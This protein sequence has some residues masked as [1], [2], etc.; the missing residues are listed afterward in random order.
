[1]K[2]KD[3][4]FKRAIS[5]QKMTLITNNASVT[6]CQNIINNRM[7][8]LFSRDI[9]GEDFLNIRL[10]IGDVKLKC[11]IDYIKPDYTPEKDK[12]LD[13]IDHLIEENKYISD[14]PFVISL[15][16]NNII[17]FILQHRNL[18]DDYMMGILLQLITYHSYF[19]LKL[20]VLTSNNL[21]E[22]S[23]LKYNIKC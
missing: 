17:A 7:P 10:G 8:E 12:L 15:K 13:D 18:Y 14:A 4:L 2:E 20:V 23:F 9:D 21:S 16:K 5:E 3:E 1:M 11:K 6:E 22:I 19:D